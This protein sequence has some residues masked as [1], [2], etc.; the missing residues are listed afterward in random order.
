MKLFSKIINWKKVREIFN[1]ITCINKGE[2]N[3]KIKNPDKTVLVLFPT[4]HFFQYRTSSF[5]LPSTWLTLSVKKG[6]S[7]TY[8]WGINEFNKTYK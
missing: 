5:K 8:F 3:S 1:E 2:Y 6:R 7:E 4:I